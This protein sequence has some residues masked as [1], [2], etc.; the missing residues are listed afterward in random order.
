MVFGQ[1]PRIVLA[2][3]CAF[4]AGEFVNS[5]VLAR[6][7]MWTAGTASVGAHDRRRRWSGRGSTA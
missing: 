6:M 5:F 2:S 4:W 3:I 1:V 7:K